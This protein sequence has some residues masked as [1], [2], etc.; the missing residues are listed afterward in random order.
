MNEDITL[1]QLIEKTITLIKFLLRRWV[2]ILAVTI[3]CGVT[4]YF[5][6]K[7]SAP[8]Y[9]A[10]SSFGV[11]G[12]GGSGLQST[13][14]AIASQLGFSMGSSG[15]FP[16]NK[17][18]VGISNSRRAIKTCLLM[19]DVINNKKTTLANFFI[20]HFM[21]SPDDEIHHQIVSTDIE[22][23]TATEDSLLDIIYEKITKGVLNVTVDEEVGLVKLKITSSNYE[24]SKHLSEKIVWFLNDFFVTNQNLAA[25]TNLLVAQKKSDSLLNALKNK[26]EQLAQ[27]N[28]S[29][30]S[31][32]KSEGKIEQGRL[33]RDIFILTKMY[34]ESAA[35]V[36]LAKYSMMDDKS[37][38]IL[39]DEPS[40]C[41]KTKKKS[42]GIYGIIF[43]F[44]GFF[45][46]T[47]SLIAANRLKSILN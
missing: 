43:A 14:M 31:T 6:A 30:I 8:V 25:K 3:L 27:L 46:V 5:L 36:E 20:Q 42:K 1:K 47:G 26:E 37:I 15:V 9:E 21:E 17:M 4:G 45:L 28:D 44:V 7:F 29:R 11:E 24:F 12:K 22:K 33:S 19:P 16:D 40:Y 38:L 32:I 34:G 10:N 39:V 2:L 35:N 18:L 13:A 23:L 41:V